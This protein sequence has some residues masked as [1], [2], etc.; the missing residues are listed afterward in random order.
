[1]VWEGKCGRGRLIFWGPVSTWLTLILTFDN[2]HCKG[3]SEITY[4]FP[5]F[6]GEAVEV[7]EWISN[8]I[9]PLP[10]HEITYL[11]WDSLYLYWCTVKAFKLIHVSKCLPV[12]LNP[13][14]TYTKYM[15]PI[16]PLSSHLLINSWN[17]TWYPIFQ[18]CGSLVQLHAAGSGWPWPKPAGQLFCVWPYNY[19]SSVDPAPRGLPQETMS[20]IL[21]L[22]A[23]CHIRHVVFA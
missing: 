22:P 19:S 17:M 6:T 16:C 11:F 7:W 12:I 9:P 1:M 21:M 8:F 3:C 15:V 4:P 14:H 18:A 2:I 13:R 10:G 23:H 5:T 20:T